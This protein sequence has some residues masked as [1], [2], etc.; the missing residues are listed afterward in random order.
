MRLLLDE[1]V[2]Q[3]FKNDLPGHDVHTVHE[4]GWSSKRNGELLEL[5]QEQDFD[6]LITVDQNVE[7]QQ[8]VA[9]LK[10]AIIVIIARSNRLEEI[11]RAAA[12]VLLALAN[13]EPGRVVSVK[14]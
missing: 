1:C 5:M 8:N 4:M 9:A 14:A 6:C 12:K 7:N 11:R 10:I 13:M 2:P 3:K